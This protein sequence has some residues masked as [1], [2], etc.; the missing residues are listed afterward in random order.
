MDE[1]KIDSVSA[2]VGASLGGCTALCM[3]AQRPERVN[4][5]LAVSCTAKTSA[6]STALRHVQ[7]D[8]IRLDPLYKKGFYSSDAPPL[9]GLR[10]ARQLGMITYRSLEEFSERF[11]HHAKAPIEFAEKLTFDVERYLRYKSEQFAGVYDA[12]CFLTMSLCSDLMDLSRN[13]ESFAKGIGRIDA[14]TL[15]IGVANDIII[16]FDEQYK[17]YSVMKALGKDV[18]LSKYYSIYGHD[19]FFVDDHFFLPKIRTFLSGAL[20]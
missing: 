5:L 11:E 7:R 17:L 18:E 9:A 14:K 13:Q 16:P 3:A 15:I 19:A 20:L 8:A 10:L 12:N 4:R 2:I 6:G 1:L